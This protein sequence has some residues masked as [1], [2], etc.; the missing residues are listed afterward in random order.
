MHRVK[1]VQRS[2]PP[3][4]GT[5]TKNA[6]RIVTASTALEKNPSERNHMYCLSKC[7]HSKEA[8]Y[9]QAKRMQ[10]VE[11]TALD[12]NKL[13]YFPPP[14]P[15]PLAALLDGAIQINAS[16]PPACACT[17]NIHGSKES[18]WLGLWYLL[19]YMAP[20]RVSEKWVIVSSA[21]W[22]QI[23]EWL[24]IAIVGSML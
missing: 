13:F 19:Q 8:L 15:H 17:E 7:V 14:H 11:Y 21:K 4:C 10:T 16:F 5:D 20:H 1:L 6:I 18:A 12:L 2:L 9:I 23:S 22:A 24:R 3:T